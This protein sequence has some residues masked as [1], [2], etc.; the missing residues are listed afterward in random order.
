[1]PSTSLELG[2]AAREDQ[3]IA[4]ADVC[5]DLHDGGQPRCHGSAAE[6][7]AAQV[8]PVQACPAVA[9]GS[10]YGGGL[11]SLLFGMLHMVEALNDSDHLRSASAE[12][13][14]GLHE[15]CLYRRS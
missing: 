3:N 12:R 7:L 6:V 11:P 5:L 1:M 4:L 13:R 15:V 9:R 10:R 8:G 14:Q 2:R